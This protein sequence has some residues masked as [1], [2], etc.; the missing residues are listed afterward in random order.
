MT[1]NVTVL[2][3]HCI[4]QSADYRL[5]D[6]QTN[7]TTD[8]QTQKVFIVNAFEWSATVCFTGV[9]RTRNPNLNVHEWLS[10]QLGLVQ[11]NDPFERLIDELLKAKSWLSAVPA[12]QNKHS[13]S[14]GAFLGSKPVF[15]L[16]S[17]FER[18]SGHKLSKASK[19]LSVFE[20]R[21]NKPKVF[22]PGLTHAVTREERNRLRALAA[23]NPAPERMHSLLAEVNRN[24]ARRIDSISPACFTTHL[25][26]TGEGD[27]RAHDVGNT[28]LP[29][30]I[31]MPVEIRTMIHQEL[32]DRFG[33][34]QWRVVGTAIGRQGVSEEYH[35]TQL[36]EKPD[37]P[38]V[39]SNYGVFL[40]ERKGDLEGAE[41]EYRMAI[42]LDP[43]HVNGL[44][45]LANLVSEKGDRDQ[46][47]DLYRQALEADPGNENVTW[48]FT[49]FLV[50]ER[51]DRMAAQDLLDKGI[52]AHPE[53]GRLLMRR[54]EFSLDGGSSLKA[55]EG[56]R[57]A[58]EKRADQ[59]RVEAGYACALQMSGAPVGECIAAYHTT[60]NLPGSH[61]DCV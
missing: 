58:R 31:A 3:S 33:P 16:I 48:N 17:N 20:V 38:S 7:T 9:G 15:V 57:Q 19:S 25:Q 1:L 42:E 13:F 49:N 6:L 51:N 47:A 43:N 26:L 5:K 30:P 29:D 60:L 39:H 27:T 45:N 2:T 24:A 46:A 14:V 61:F 34:G 41:R 35:K 12:P 52:L 53:S 22:V 23:Q 44:G 54:A 11:M 4:Y 18:P 28:S 50:R 21:V 55:L 10:G 56:F 59:A 36:S 40:K 8:F 37:D 32:D